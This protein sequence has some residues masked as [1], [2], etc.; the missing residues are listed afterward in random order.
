VV[1]H[2][3]NAM[4]W[5]LHAARGGHAE[6]QYRVGLANLYSGGMLGVQALSNLRLA[7]QQR[8][9]GAW[10]AYAGYLISVLENG[11]PPGATGHELELHE[12]Q[13][14]GL[15]KAA[16]AAGSPHAMTMLGDCFFDGICVSE[17]PDVDTAFMWYRRAV[18][19]G[20][21]PA[22][23]ALARHLEEVDGVDDHPRE[24]LD[25]YL[26]AASL[27]N[28]EGAYMCGIIFNHPNYG[29]PRNPHAA[30]SF[31][32][33]AARLGHETA[34]SEAADLAAALARGQSDDEA[35]DAD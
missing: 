22:M 19:K 24:I 18:A 10:V 17:E 26:R 6:S 34:A 29:L 12:A 9:V 3:L 35:D 15:L 8:H 5:F 27:G 23:V 20:H 33:L 7:V 14:T 25:L 1:V 28:D 11:G 30:L 21:A 16:A 2:K 32:R 4:Q 31:Y 13:V